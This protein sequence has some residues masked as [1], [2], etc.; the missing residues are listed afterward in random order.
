MEKGARVQVSVNLYVVYSL[1]IYLLFIYLLFICCLFICCFFAVYFLFIY[2]LLTGFESVA[3]A[4][5]HIYLSISIYNY[6][7]IGL[8]ERHC[9]SVTY[10]A[11][12]SVLREGRLRVLTIGVCL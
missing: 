8:Y 2:S 7:H 11:S 1:F 12:G 9:S 4:I 3:L 10:S 5:I 6:V